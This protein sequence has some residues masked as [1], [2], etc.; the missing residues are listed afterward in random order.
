[1]RVTFKSSFNKSDFPLIN[2]LINVRTSTAKPRTMNLNLTLSDGI[3][4][5]SCEAAVRS[6]HKPLWPTVCNHKY[7]EARSGISLAFL[8]II[9]RFVIYCGTLDWNRHIAYID[10][11]FGFMVVSCRWQR[12]RVFVSTDSLEYCA[13]NVM[14]FQSPFHLS[15][16]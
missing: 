5:S 12:V 15:L 6:E 4:T 11:P 3:I 16:Q 2:R 9:Q 7:Y 8:Q 1:M 14:K 13:W 10:F